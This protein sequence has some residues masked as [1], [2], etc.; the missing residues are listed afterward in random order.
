MVAVGSKGRHKK[1]GKG[2]RP[3][4]KKKSQ[5]KFS[6]EVLMKKLEPRLILLKDRTC[7]VVRTV[8]ELLKWKDSVCSQLGVCSHN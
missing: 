3:T 5:R 1:A 4:E 2:D 8:Q 6:G 7:M